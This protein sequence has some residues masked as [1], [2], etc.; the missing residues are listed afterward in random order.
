MSLFFNHFKNSARRMA[1]IGMV[2]VRALPATPRSTL[3]VQQL[4]DKA[5]E[6]AAVYSNHGLDG[7][8]IENMFDIPYVTAADSG[9]EITAVMGR[10]ASEVRKVCPRSMPC[11]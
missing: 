3:S 6:E 11:G 2:H 8:C 1:I 9:P 7:V 5:C 10:V 4:V